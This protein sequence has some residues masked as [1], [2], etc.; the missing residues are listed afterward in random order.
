MHDM[1]I[2]TVGYMHYL[3]I[4]NIIPRCVTVA[5]LKFTNVIVLN[6]VC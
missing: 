2:F 6:L 4:E 5:G 3:S 1:Y